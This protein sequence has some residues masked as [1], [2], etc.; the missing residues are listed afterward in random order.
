M[1]SKPIRTNDDYEAALAEIE[2]LFD[3]TP[4]TPEYDRLEVLSIL[5]EAYESEHY[6]IPLPHPV[7]AIEYYIESRG[8]ERKDLE[9]FIGS[10]GRVSEILNKR[11]CLTLNMIR[12]LEA[13]LGI[14]AEILI[15]PYELEG[16]AV[17][18]TVPERLLGAEGI[19][20]LPIV[21]PSYVEQAWG[22]VMT[23]FR[24]VGSNEPVEAPTYSPVPDGLSR[25]QL[26]S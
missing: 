7:E 13:G 21:L 8:L 19:E 3:S 5:V 23:G 16:E 25:L 9:P 17:S 26:D 2:N 15:Q 1:N 22:D 4:G 18:D 14:P 24:L 12:R 10:R 20:R 6:P 11:R